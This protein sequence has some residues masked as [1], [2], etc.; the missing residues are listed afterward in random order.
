MILHQ[1]LNSVGN[2]AYN[3]FVYTDVV[4]EPHIHKNYEAICVLDGS[5]TVRIYETDIHLNRNEILLIPPYFVHTINVKNAAV[6]IAVFSEDYISEYAGAYG[7]CFFS[8]FVTDEKTFSFLKENLFYE[9]TPDLFTAK[10]CLYLLCKNCI[11]NAKPVVTN[12]DIDFIG[13]LTDYISTHIRSGLT[14]KNTA[15]AMGFEYHYFSSLFHK[16][17]MTSFTDFVN[18]YKF[19]SACNLLRNEEMSISDIAF[20]CGFGS[21]RNFN[22][23]FKALSGITPAEFRKGEK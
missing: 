3:A 16:Y 10:A 21:I 1:L 12:L 18:N 23:I 7:R 19:E 15:A 9:G 13:Q 2:H 5:T 8:K 17:F 4:H 22:R 11:E 14:M 20:E 6:W